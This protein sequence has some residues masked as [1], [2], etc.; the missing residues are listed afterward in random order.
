MHP[1]RYRSE[2]SSLTCLEDR[3]LMSVNIVITDNGV[4]ANEIIVSLNNEILSIIGTTSD[5]KVEVVDGSTADEILVRSSGPIAGGIPAKFDASLVKR[6]RFLGREGNDEFRVSN[7]RAIP[8]L[9]F[10]DVGDDILVG[11]SADDAL[12]GGPGNDSLDGG[13]GDDAMFG[14]GGTNTNLDSQGQ[15]LFFDGEPIPFVGPLVPGFIN[16][17]QHGFEGI[18]GS[19]AFDLSSAEVKRATGVDVSMV[20]EVLTIVGGRANDKVM[21]DQNDGVVS[22]NVVRGGKTYT[23]DFDADAMKSLRFEGGA[24]NDELRVGESF[25]MAVSAWGQDGNDLLIGGSGN[26]EL[27]GGRGNDDLRGQAGDD[28]LAGDQGNDRLRGGSGKNVMNDLIGRNQMFNGAT[29]SP[30]VVTPARQ[31]SSRRRRVGG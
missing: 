1:R 6:I 4:N 26:D 22:V 29:D 30:V 17:I 20:D 3:C 5:D 31:T 7:S 8:V 19:L 25:A 21:V 24:G 10:G 14:D 11:G 28:L 2:V 13:V 12:A 9:A 16:I 18:E 23:L 27:H 15:N